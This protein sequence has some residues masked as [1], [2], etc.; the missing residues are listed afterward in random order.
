MTTRLI[1]V[2]G[3]FKWYHWAAGVGT[4]GVFNVSIFLG[5]GKTYQWFF[6]D[7]ASCEQ[8]FRDKYGL[9]TEAQRLEIFAW[10]ANQWDA[11][12]GVGETSGADF[13][14]KELFANATGEV[15]EVAVGTGRCF[16]A[17]KSAD[18][19]KSYVGI[20]LVAQMLDEARPKLAGLPFPAR[21]ERAN[22]HRLPY[23]TGS[24]DTVIGSLCLCSLE[25]PQEALDE[26]ARVCKD[27]GQVLLLEPGLANSMAVRSVQRQL[28]LVPQPKHAWEF[29][30][31]DDRHPPSLVR[32]CTKLSLT[33]KQ[34]KTMGNW[35]LLK[36]RPAAPADGQANVE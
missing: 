1:T 15:L 31:Y 13:Y 29:G 7:E 30:W 25:R 9:P 11:K 35:Y 6:A 10:L 36:A 34:T 14:R 12:I 22:A 4:A 23:A 17:L 18:S 26:M 27:E 2:A 20:D 5:M 33:S 21:L 32:T 24:F 19:V 16:E 3:K 28:G 8:A